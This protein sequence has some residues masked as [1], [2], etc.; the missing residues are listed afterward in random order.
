VNGDALFWAVF[1]WLAFLAFCALV[2]A[3]GW[4]KKPANARPWLL[5]AVC[6]ALLTWMALARWA[7]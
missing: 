4:V 1:A 3:A 7:S 6:P 2:V 5:L